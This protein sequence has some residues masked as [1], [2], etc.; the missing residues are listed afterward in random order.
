MP[1]TNST[2]SRPGHDVGEAER[3][4]AARRAKPI[5]GGA[6][7]FNANGALLCPPSSHSVV[8]LSAAALRTV[9]A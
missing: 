9:T 7:A 6:G 3:E 5:D 2:W 4:I 8:G 1:S